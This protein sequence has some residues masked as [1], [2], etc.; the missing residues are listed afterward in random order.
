MIPIPQ[1]PELELK[2]A[3]D[4][5]IKFMQI[6]EADPSILDHIFEQLLESDKVKEYFDVWA[7]K[8]PAIK[9]SKEAFDSFG[10]ILTYNLFKN[11][12]LL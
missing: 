11:G 4:E 3:G 1:F 10:S 8:F 2:V 7:S 9:S 12:D 5:V 6:V